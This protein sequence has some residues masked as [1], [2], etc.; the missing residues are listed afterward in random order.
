MSSTLGDRRTNPPSSTPSAVR[1]AIPTSSSPRPPSFLVII[2]AIS[3]AVFAGLFGWSFYEWRAAPP[4]SPPPP[5]PQ[6]PLVPCPT[7]DCTC[8]SSPTGFCTCNG[9]TGSLQPL[10]PYPNNKIIFS[11]SKYVL[12]NMNGPTLTLEVIVE[13]GSPLNVL[14]ITVFD[15][16]RPSENGEAKAICATGNWIQCDNTAK[17][18]RNNRDTENNLIGEPI[19]N[20][21]KTAFFCN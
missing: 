8:A 9:S 2:L 3:T 13:E 15:V 20:E 18:I 19:I 5:P 16:D 14:N 11:P 12:A 21:S 10:S 4:Q 1:V 17:V 6:S 7:Q